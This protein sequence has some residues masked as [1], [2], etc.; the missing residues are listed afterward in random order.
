[1]PDAK[2]ANNFCGIVKALQSKVAGQRISLRDS[3]SSS[4]IQSEITRLADAMGKPWL[5][6][7]S[8]SYLH[9][10]VRQ[11]A[12]DLAAEPIGGETRA[13]FLA[14]LA[15]L[16]A[17]SERKL[18]IAPVEGITVASDDPVVFG[19]F[20]LRRATQNE[21]DRIHA[22]TAEAVSGSANTPSE[23]VDI[24]SELRR[25]A[26][27]SLASS[28]LLEFEV[29]AET[30][31]AH[32]IFIEKAAMLMD[33]LQMSTR[34]AEFCRSARIGLRGHPHSGSYSAWIL[35]LNSG[36]FYQPNKRT[37]GIGYLSLH[38]GNLFLMRRAGVM[39]LAEALG[40]EATLLESAL[41]RAVH[42]Y[43]QSTLQE[44]VGH[45][46][47]CLV[48]SLEAVLSSSSGR[49]NAESVALLVGSNPQ[50][51][52]YLDSLVR[53]AYLARNLV[54]HEG[55]SGHAFSRQEEFRTVVREFIATVIRLCDEFQT[56]HDLI[57]RVGD[58]RFS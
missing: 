24:A 13:R 40:R 23:Q 35:P 45:E 52:W 38:D 27:E 8:A 50:Q 37:G 30:K 31:Q 42:W 51:R 5:E 18:C 3:A 53:E 46:T 16:D 1:M 54:V 9:D 47:L 6:R 25:D 57:R 39:R 14:L 7:F 48:V 10:R 41:L 19:P 56:P 21:L 12:L 55:K 44:H 26:E 58:L 11:L 22:L 20:V 36:G 33:L 34:I 15:E 4:S 2:L 17:F 43:A 32:A 49:A 28:V 29:T